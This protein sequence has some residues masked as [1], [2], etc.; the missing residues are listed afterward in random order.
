[1]SRDEIAKQLRG[2]RK[3]VE[4]AV[5]AI[6]SQFNQIRNGGTSSV[7]SSALRYEV[8]VLRQI[9]CALQDNCHKYADL[10]C[11]I[12]ACMLPHV[13]ICEAK[14]E[15][16]VSHLTS[17]HYIHHAIC[18]EQTMLECQR[19]YALINTQRVQLQSKTDYKLYM[20]THIKHLYFFNQQMQKQPTST[21]QNQLCLVLQAMGVL[22]QAMQRQGAGYSE[23]IV[24]SNQILGKRSTTFLRILGKLPVAYANKMYEPLFKLLSSSG[25]TSEELSTQFPEYLSAVLALIQIDGFAWQQQA[26]EEHQPWALQ[27]LRCCRE[28]YQELTSHNY[29]MQLL[30]YYL[31]L[32]YTR[33]SA[34]T[35]DLKRHYIDLAKKLIKFFEHKG[36]AQ[37]QEQWFIDFLMVF[38]RVQKLLLQIDG[39]KNCFEVF[40][41]GL[42]GTD[43]AEAYAAHFDLLQC[44]ITMSMNISSSSPLAASCSNDA[45]CQSLRKHCI[46]SLGC[47]ALAAY[48]NWQPSAQATLPK[49]AQKVLVG[50]I[51]YAMDVVK[52]TKCM[53]ATSGELVSFVWHLTNIA[54]K[55]SSGPQMALLQLLLRPLQQLR[56]LLGDQEMRQLLR[57]IY[58]AS[59]YCD[60]PE[61]A[62][63]MHCTYIAAMSCPSRQFQQM[64]V[65]YRSAKNSSTRCIYELHETSPLCNPLTTA[66]RRKLYELDM[67]AVLGNLKTPPLLQSLLRHRQT[68]Y[69]LVLLGR[70]MRTDPKM[71]GQLEELR[72]KLQQKE[73][74]TR[75]E[76]LV[77]GHVS[78]SKLLE[79]NEAQKTKI[80]IKET[81]EKSL[82]EM[83][84][85]YNLLDVNIASEMPRVQLAT[86]AIDAFEAFYNLADAEPLSSDEALIDWE[87]L[88]DD[89]IWA[90]MALSSMGYMP[91]A[92]KAW[93]LLLRIG[94]QLGDR[95]TYLRALSHFMAHYTQHALFDMPHEVEHA[96]QLLDELWPQIHR[97]HFYKR[98]HSTLM[99]CLCQMG[100]YYAR[101]DCASHAQLL[102]LHAERLRDQFEERVGKCDIVQ[103]TLQSVRFRICYQQRQCSILARMPTALQQL[104][105]L[106]DGVRSF[107]AIS[108]MDQSVF[109]LLLSDLVRDS[110]ECTANRLSERP[111]LS[112]SLL[113]VLLQG[114]LLLRTV[115]VLI[116]WLWTNLRMECLD[117]ALSKLRLIE[118]FLCIQP[119]S[120]ERQISKS[121]SLITAPMDAQSKHMS[122]LVGK[123]ISMQL[124]HGAASVEPIRKQQQLAVSSPRLEMQSPNASRLKL[125]RYLQESHPVMRDSIQLQC[126]YFIVGCLRARL[127]FL[128]REHDQLDE[129]Y[130]MAND[131]LQR[132]TE[133]S[134][135][136]GHMLLVLQVYQANYLRATRKYRQ[137][138]EITESALKLA[139]SEQLQQRVDVNYRYNLLLQLRTAQLEL[140]PPTVTRKQQQ[141]RRALKFNISPEDKSKDKSKASK[142]PPK[143]TIYTEDSAPSSGSSMESNSSPEENKRFDLN[144]CQLIEIIDSS[145]EEPSPPARPVVTATKS[146]PRTA[147]ATRST[148]T[149]SQKQLETPL[150][151]ARRIATAPNALGSSSRRNVTPEETPKTTTSTRA[152]P[153]RQNAVE[154]QPVTP[155]LKME[156]VSSRRRQR[157]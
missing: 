59:K 63:Q 87:A 25:A 35:V 131:W 74:L 24:E 68:D 113:Q 129:F 54:D 77:L 75:L 135:A 8:V 44:L 80:P 40:W 154:E 112:S 2:T 4:S 148:R 111:N 145:E 33:D 72:L 79:L 10:Y 142:K 43:S 38:L 1:M 106:V 94:R 93:L 36:A 128:S 28:S 147:Q 146:L 91:P 39:K 99:L 15:L 127:N 73:R 156:S 29:V 102:L 31:K 95:F 11:D 12:V 138:I 132:D 153:R 140:Q 157:N 115:E 84:I 6:R 150:V 56:P 97:A 88:I 52:V 136:L 134:N 143:F 105:T 47:C 45:N 100:L 149:R 22:F 23:L 86:A 71:L 70:Q 58:K 130:G 133:R 141:P 48:S 90:A 34:Q 66:Q 96:Q 32:L 53:V 82:E 64:G 104:D 121:S 114:G 101:S 49:A 19:F 118:H 14:P 5:Q 13:E 83:L 109:V 62:A 119:L 17:L 76:Q 55:V 122:E 21:A 30:Y 81:A 60:S 16:W 27:L 117:K 3:E 92:D 151:P 137:A 120:L 18:Q 46:F 57:R 41:R 50:I 123:M 26:A 110:T 144:S 155:L 67:L 20:N 103:L 124:E 108:S 78:V 98:Q 51:H 107:T 9:C 7:A 126:I 42:G 89:A 61:L 37:A 152:R 85:K 125:L 139:K 69:Q 116:S 65:F